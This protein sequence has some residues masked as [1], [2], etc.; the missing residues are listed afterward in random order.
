VERSKTLLK[1]PAVAK[2]FKMNRG[3]VYRLCREGVIPSFR[4][5]GTRAIRVPAERLQEWIDAQTDSK[6][7]RQAKEGGGIASGQS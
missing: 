4:I 3:L 7:D 1:V 2:R 5:P 6:T